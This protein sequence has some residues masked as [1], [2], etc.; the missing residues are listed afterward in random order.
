MK[1]FRKILI[2]SIIC[3]LLITSFVSCAK[4]SANYDAGYDTINNESGNANQEIVINQTNRKIIYTVNIEMKTSNFNTTLD[5]LYDA[6]QADTEAA[7]WIKNSSI[8]NNNNYQYAQLC[9]KVKTSTLNAFVTNL[10]TIGTVTSQSSDSDDITYNYA[11]LEAAI[12]ASEQEKIY[13]ENLIDNEDI[14]SNYVLLEQYISKITE[15]NSELAL[16][17]DQLIKYDNDLEYSTVNINLNSYTTEDTEEV[18]SFGAK[19]IKVFKDSIYSLVA[20]FKGLIIVVVAI[21]P[22]VVVIG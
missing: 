12:T 19:I 18:L 14:Q 5:A 1:K 13:Y 7:N 17:N 9:I 3:I 22:Y 4:E 20:V 21:A 11:S 6:V 2:L 16:M 8:N 10:S 15:I